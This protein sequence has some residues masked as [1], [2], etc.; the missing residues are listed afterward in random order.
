M[1][2]SRRN[3][4]VLKILVVDILKQDETESIIIRRKKNVD[5]D[6]TRDLSISSMLSGTL[7][8][9]FAISASLKYASTYSGT[10]TQKKKKRNIVSYAGKIL[11][12]YKS[13]K[14]TITLNKIRR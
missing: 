9:A 11:K 12:I 4:R 14:S 8:R 1:F 3:A 6:V 10:V 2:K 5:K 13:E 7:F